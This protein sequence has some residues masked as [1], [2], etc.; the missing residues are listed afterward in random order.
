M[1]AQFVFRILLLS[2]LAGL[3]ASCAHTSFAPVRVSASTPGPWPPLREGQPLIIDFKAGD[4]IPVSLQVDGEIIETTPSPST[5]W[6]TAKRDFSVRIRGSEIKTSLNGTNFEQKP[7]V[8]GHFQ[9]GLEATREGG[10]K[11]VVRITTPVHQK[12]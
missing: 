8:P 12:P 4:R 5:I 1:T 2:A 6:L 7:A 3:P 11:V 10:A 9:F